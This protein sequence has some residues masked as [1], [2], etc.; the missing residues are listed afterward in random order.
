MHRIYE[1]KVGD[2]FTSLDSVSDQYTEA[3]FNRKW[4]KIKNG[5]TTIIDN[6]SYAAQAKQLVE[7]F[8]LELEGVY[9]PVTNA[10][11]VA[12]A[13]F[14]L[15]KNFYVEIDNGRNMCSLKIRHR[16][17]HAHHYIDY[18]AVNSAT[19]NEPAR[20][21]LPEGANIPSVRNYAYKVALRPI[22][23]KIID[24]N[25]MEIYLK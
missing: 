8:D 25:V 12:K 17:K 1:A 7:G 22:K 23:T 9:V 18:S 6:P 11:K 19:W 4:I 10:M 16:K 21:Q 15:T 20:I 13:V 5:I 3:T 14:R 24:N 2:S